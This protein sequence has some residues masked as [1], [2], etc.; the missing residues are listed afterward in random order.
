MIFR[1]ALAEDV[2][3]MHR[4]R[5]VVKENSL[6]NP[7][8]I[9]LDDYK[10][11]LTHRGNGWVCESEG[12]IAGFAIVD[13]QEK[14]VWALFVMPGFEGKGI[15]KQLHDKM[16]DW[17]FSKTTETIWL[18]TAP[19]TRAELFYRKAGWKQTAL[20]PNG[21]IRFEMTTEYWKNK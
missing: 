17:Y 7:D 2:P 5:V 3:A 11:F 20:R 16:L 21:E 13:L 6:P 9:K 19:G 4:V 14:N 12:A 18:G 10:K 8:L 1:K 15:G